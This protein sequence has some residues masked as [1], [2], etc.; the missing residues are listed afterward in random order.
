MADFQGTRPFLYLHC[1]PYIYLNKYTTA[2]ENSLN[3]DHPISLIQH[4]NKHPRTAPTNF[5]C[6]LPE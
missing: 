1:F 2:L 3:C 6:W 4:K 5:G